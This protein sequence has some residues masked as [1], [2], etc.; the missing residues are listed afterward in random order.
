[1]RKFYN[2]PSYEIATN[3]V[4]NIKRNNNFTKKEKLSI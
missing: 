1:M 4:A 3:I 2:I